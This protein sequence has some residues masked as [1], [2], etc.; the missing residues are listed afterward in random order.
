MASEGDIAI[1]NDATP[2]EMTELYELYT[3]LHHQMAALSQYNEVKLVGDEI[4]LTFRDSGGFP[5]EIKF[6]PLF[7]SQKKKLEEYGETV[8]NLGALSDRFETQRLNL[9]EKEL[10]VKGFQEEASDLNAKLAK[11]QTNESISGEMVDKLTEIVEKKNG[12]I[13]T[14]ESQLANLRKGKK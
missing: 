11:S 7:D 14:L 4:I 12:H 6:E 9:E 2:R 10:Q 3:K 8:E 13:E 5:H 1:R